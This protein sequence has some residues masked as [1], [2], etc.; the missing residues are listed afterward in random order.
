MT[1]TSVRVIG[2]IGMACLLACGGCKKTRGSRGGLDGRDP[3]VIADRDRLGMDEIDLGMELERWDPDS[4]GT[5]IAG[6]FSP[7]YFAYD[8]ARV[9]AE[10]RFKADVALEVL[11]S[12][13][14]SRMIVEGHCDERGSR[15]YNLALGERRAQAVRAYLIGLGIDGTR[16]QTRSFGEENPAEMG[17]DESSYRLN[18]RAEFLL[19]E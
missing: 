19:F 6:E 16:I 4:L 3:N 8:S 9:A 13:S 12:N 5:P 2:L 11:R 14:A 10:E 15:E 7:V 17:H 1:K 18:R